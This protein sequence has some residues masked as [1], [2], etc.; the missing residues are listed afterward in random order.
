MIRDLSILQNNLQYQ[1]S[2]ISLLELALTHRSKRKSH[3]ERLE[4]LGDA[5]LSAIVAEDLYFKFPLAKEGKLSQMRTALVRGGTLTELAKI[6]ELNEYIEF[7]ES[8]LKSGG[9]KRDRVLE[10][11]FE[12]II[13]AI[14]LDKGFEVT[15]TCVLSW[16]KDKL[17]NLSLASNVKDA[18]TKLQEILQKNNLDLPVYR[19]VKEEGM[20]HE[21]IFHIQCEIAELNECVTVVAR[22]RKQGENQTA[23]ILCDK[24]ASHH[25]ELLNE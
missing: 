14:Y 13:G 7:G 4:F 8:E 18:K 24:I 5:I 23:Q 9:Y 17:E 16:Y 21:K 22:R 19:V 11:A 25:P 1:F 15:K 20:A 6:F 12:A 10:D 2:D 3:N